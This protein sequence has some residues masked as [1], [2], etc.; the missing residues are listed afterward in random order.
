MYIG[1]NSNIGTG[2]NAGP[3]NTKL[4]CNWPLP[5]DVGNAGAIQCDVSLVDGYSLNVQCQA[6][7]ALDPNSPTSIGYP[8]NLNDN[9]PNACQ[10]PDTTN[11]YCANKNGG[12]T[13]G[14]SGVDPYFDPAASTCY[15]WSNPPSPPLMSFLSGSTGATLDC[16][17]SPGFAGGSSSKKKRDGGE[18][19]R[20]A[21]D[22]VLE[23]RKLEDMGVLHG[24]S[25]K[26]R[27]HA[28]GMRMFVGPHKH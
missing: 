25:H 17:V 23:P 20:I 7:S 9:N 28:R 8:G 10:A 2:S 4:E 15:I 13:S 14:Q 3:G 16:T 26:A 5:Q 6:G 22:D 27:A 24:L 19:A 18:I 1:P 11:G 12:T 21:L